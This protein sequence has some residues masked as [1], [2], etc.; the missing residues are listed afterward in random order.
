MTDPAGIEILIG[1]IGILLALW[2]TSYLQNSSGGRERR[3]YEH[4]INTLANDPSMTEEKYIH[5]F[6]C[7][8]DEGHIIGDNE[9]VCAGCG[10]KLA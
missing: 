9:V 8:W 1:F 6:R 3:D 10:F 4:M 7:D 2:A 5:T